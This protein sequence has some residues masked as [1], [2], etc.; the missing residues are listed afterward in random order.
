MESLNFRNDGA[1]VDIVRWIEVVEETH[2]NVLEL[3]AAIA[4]LIKT[5][6]HLGQPRERRFI[7]FMD[8]GSAITWINRRF[9]PRGSHNRNLVSKLIEFLFNFEATN[10]IALQ[11][12]MCPV[13][14]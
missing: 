10:D 3:A 11:A 13:H 6:L 4:T 9:I 2:I 12:A 14:S 7:C 1:L 5:W 8:N